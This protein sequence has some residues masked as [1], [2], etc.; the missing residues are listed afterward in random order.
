MV[1]LKPM[2]MQDRRRSEDDV[3]RIMLSLHVL[4]AGHIIMCSTLH[5]LRYLTIGVY[6]ANGSLETYPILV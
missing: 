4:L 2:E 3:G 6:V 1:M 5:G